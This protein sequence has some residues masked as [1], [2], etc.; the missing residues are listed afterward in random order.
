MI[1]TVKIAWER[2][3][4]W[5]IRV[6]VVT[7][8]LMPSRRR[9][10]QCPIVCT[11]CIVRSVDKN[12]ITATRPKKVVCFNLLKG[13]QSPKMDLGIADF[14]HGHGTSIWDQFSVMCPWISRI[15]SA[16]TLAC[17][18]VLDAVFRAKQLR[19]ERMSSF[20]YWCMT[21]FVPFRSVN[22]LYNYNQKITNL[23]LNTLT[24]LV[25][26]RCFP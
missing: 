23:L 11:L 24:N 18:C 4:C 22:Q 15:V 5:F 9:F 14:F 19:K 1:Q 2:E 7:R 3:E 20:L 17:K 26:P 25:W 10:A 6:A 13:F 8:H 16:G 21:D 12:K